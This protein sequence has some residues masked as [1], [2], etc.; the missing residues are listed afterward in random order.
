M[1]KRTAVLA[2]AFLV[3][4]VWVLPSAY[5]VEMEISAELKTG[6][7]WNPI[8]QPSFRLHHSDYAGDSVGR[9]RMGLHFRSGD[10]GIRTRFGQTVW[11]RDAP[12]TGIAQMLDVVRWDFA[13]AYGNFLSEQLRISA[14]MLTGSPWRAGRF[15]RAS[16]IDD[17][18]WQGLDHLVGIRT[19][20]MP[21]V[22]PGLNVGFTLNT[23]NQMRYWPAERE[24]F[25]ALLLETVF[26]VAYSHPLFY[27]R[28]SWRLDS[29][30]DVYNHQQEGHSMMFRLEPLFISNFVPDF[31]MWVNGWWLGVGPRYIE[32]GRYILGDGSYH[33]SRVPD[34]Q[35]VFRN[36][37]YLEY[38]P[39]DLVAEFVVGGVFT[40]LNSHIIHLQPGIYYQMLPFLRAGIHVYYEYNFG[41]DRTIGGVDIDGRNIWFRLL[42]FQPQ[43]RLQ[44]GPAELSLVYRFEME[45]DHHGHRRTNQWVNLRAVI[46]F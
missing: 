39:R 6:V 22:V 5:A 38:T 1:R 45:H 3:S 46:S 28:F 42:A 29:A 36:W 31:R 18:I 27:G 2:L 26:G 9:F 4:S 8:H 17:I 44:F 16:S 34:D 33:E 7:Y 37:L 23:W 19:E 24:H 14:G 13:Y 30:A 10:F 12:D 35:R 11:E 41:E 43:I 40:G 20:V 21:N 25:R 15:S 32:D